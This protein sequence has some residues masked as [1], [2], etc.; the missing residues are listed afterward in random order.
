VAGLVTS[1]KAMYSRRILLD[2]NRH[3]TDA[4]YYAR[5][6]A[7]EAA[8]GLREELNPVETR[9]RELAGRERD[10]EPSTPEVVRERA[11]GVPRRARQ[12]VREVRQRI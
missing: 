3:F 7:E 6:A 2:M 1:N 11:T 12:R 8:T 5:R 9:V 4:A 10:P